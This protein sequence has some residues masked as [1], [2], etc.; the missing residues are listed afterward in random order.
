MIDPEESVFIPLGRFGGGRLKEKHLSLQL[1]INSFTFLS[2]TTTELRISSLCCR[3]W[4][5]S[6]DEIRVKKFG[7]GRIGIERL[8]Q[9][10]RENTLGKATRLHSVFLSSPSDN[11]VASRR[12]SK[13]MRSSRLFNR[14]VIVFLLQRR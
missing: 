4:K 1:G 7:I 6:K 3:S 13:E 10:W 8:Y 5:A 9:V 2:S 14:E 11:S 12:F